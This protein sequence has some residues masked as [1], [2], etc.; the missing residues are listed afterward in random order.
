LFDNLT[1]ETKPLATAQSQTMML[2]PPAGLPTTAGSFIQVDISADIEAYPAWRQ[3]IKTHFRRT[4]QGWT[5]VGLE[6]MP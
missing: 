2:E 1:G 6:R 4:A 3:P 5:L